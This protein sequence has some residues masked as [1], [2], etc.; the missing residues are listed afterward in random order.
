MLSGFAIVHNDSTSALNPYSEEKCTHM[1]NGTWKGN[2]VLIRRSGDFTAKA[3]L[4]AKALREIWGGPL[5][6]ASI[7]APVKEWQKR[8][9]GSCFRGPSTAPNPPL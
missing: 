2:E 5:I 7:Y 8:D 6:S 9:F 3:E 4:C 1:S